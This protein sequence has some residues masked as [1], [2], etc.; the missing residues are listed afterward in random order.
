[1]RL[2]KRVKLVEV[3]PR[4]G[5]QNEARTVPV[6]VRV[7]LIERLADAGLTV[8]E[9]GAFVSPKW[10]P[11]MADTAEVMAGIARKPGVSY[12]VLVPNMK[13]YE[14]ARAAR[15][16]EIAVF[17]AASETFSQKNINCSIADSLA[18]FVPLMAA[19]GLLFAGHSESFLHAVDL[20]RPCGRTVYRLAA[21]AGGA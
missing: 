7:E 8:I 10:V 15:A 3:G 14:A 19:D 9:A 20:F 11:Q 6:E 2:P 5:L 12:P 1:M 21:P 17:G 18:R 4:D 16:D 13:G